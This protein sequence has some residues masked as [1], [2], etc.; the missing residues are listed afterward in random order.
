MKNPLGGGNGMVPHYS[1]T[2]LDAQAR[3]AAGTRS[4]LENYLTGNPQE[5]QNV[6]VGKSEYSVVAS[7]AWS[8][9][10][11]LSLQRATRQRR[12]DSGEPSCSQGKL[13]VL[14][15]EDTVG[16][17]LQCISTVYTNLNVSIC[18][19]HA[20]LVR[21]PR[22]LV[23][24]IPVV[25]WG[26]AGN[27]EP[28]AMSGGEGRGRDAERVF[29]VNLTLTILRRLSQASS[30]SHSGAAQYGPPHPL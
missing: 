20:I 24:W 19:D 10:D 8:G 28:T 1:G 22:A 17:A 13:L 12:T 21:C 6:I 4:I 9:T 14:K 26:N 15:A 29:A 18:N 25:M 11:C 5:P 30:A 2:T 3:Y 23:R 27:D 7:A 16:K